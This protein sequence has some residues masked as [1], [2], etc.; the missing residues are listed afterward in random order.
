MGFACQAIATQGNCLLGRDLLAIA[1]GDV[2][3]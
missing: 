1:F 3:C 2:T